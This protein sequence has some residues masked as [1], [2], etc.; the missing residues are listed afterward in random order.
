M[1]LQIRIL[2]VVLLVLLTG[3]TTVNE[4][5]IEPKEKSK[6]SNDFTVKV[7]RSTGNYGEIYERHLG[8][9]SEVPIPRGLNELY[10]KGGV[11]ISPPFN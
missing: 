2:I 6:Y 9:N 8:E 3:C 7:I 4:K 10:N 5:N 1:E 11:H